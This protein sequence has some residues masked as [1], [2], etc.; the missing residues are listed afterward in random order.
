M[1]IC[2]L[3]MNEWFINFF[4]FKEIECSFPHTICYISEHYSV[5]TLYRRRKLSLIDNVGTFIAEI[6]F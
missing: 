1:L 3:I 4:T 5:K 2:V 6:F